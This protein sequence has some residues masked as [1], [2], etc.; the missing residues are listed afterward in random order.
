MKW[1]MDQKK[2]DRQA[3]DDKG[4]LLANGATPSKSSTTASNR[5]FNH[6]LQETSWLVIDLAIAFLDVFRRSQPILTQ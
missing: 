2:N 6:F 5:I 1:T 3:E 4:S